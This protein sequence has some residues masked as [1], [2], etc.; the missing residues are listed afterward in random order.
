MTLR[1]LDLKNNQV[2]VIPVLVNEKYYG[3]V[4]MKQKLERDGL[5]TELEE[6]YSL[7]SYLDELRKDFAEI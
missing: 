4:L 1:V 2:S 6:V 7:D 5:V 3:R